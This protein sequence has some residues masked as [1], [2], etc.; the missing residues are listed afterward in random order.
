MTPAHV[1]EPPAEEPAAGGRVHREQ[2]A[3]E[4][5]DGGWDRHGCFWTMLRF[6]CGSAILWILMTI[7]IIG[8]AL[9]SLTLFR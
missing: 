5:A 9:L 8:A 4:D 6:G 7:G 3:A 2:H 1:S